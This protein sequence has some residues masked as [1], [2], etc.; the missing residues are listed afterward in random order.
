MSLFWPS[1]LTLTLEKYNYTAGETI[2]GKFILSSDTPVK[3]E[4]IRINLL[5][6][7]KNKTT[8]FSTRDIS[9]N[10]SHTYFYNQSITILP[11]WEY[12]Y[13]EL[14]FSYHIPQDIIRDEWGFFEK[15]GNLP[16]W[17]LLILNLLLS[18]TR[19]TTPRFVYQFTVTWIVDIPWGI[20]LKEKT[21]I[22]IIPMKSWNI[23]ADS[24]IPPEIQNLMNGQDVKNI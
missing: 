9:Q 19:L 5:G 6:E 12:T 8:T 7:R 17:A 14:P 2:T 24:I 1:K 18:Y 13:Q 4:G 20:D 21:A 15:L 11:A 22:E 10:S 23:Q 16:S 3:T